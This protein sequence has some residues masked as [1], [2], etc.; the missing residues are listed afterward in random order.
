MENP[1]SRNMTYLE[2]QLTYFQVAQGKTQEEKSMIQECYSDVLSIISETE[3]A[4]IAK[5]MLTEY[6]GIV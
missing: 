5:G 6:D 2:A 4:E 1:F 3:R